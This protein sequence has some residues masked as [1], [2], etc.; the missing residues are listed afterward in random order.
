[1]RKLYLA[2]SAFAALFI[3]QIGHA[4]PTIPGATDVATNDG[5]TYYALIEEGSSWVVRGYTA[6][7]QSNGFSVTLSV[8]QNAIDNANARYT[9]LAFDGTSFYALRDDNISAIN[10]DSYSVLG[11]DATGSKSSVMQLSNAQGATILASAVVYTG[12]SVAEEGFFALRNDLLS[13]KGTD[14]WSL[15]NY[16]LAGVLNRSG[17]IV[18][19]EDGALASATPFDLVSSFNASP[20]QFEVA[21]ATA[22][23]VPEPGTGLLLGSILGLGFLGRKRLKKA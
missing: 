13:P 23:D 9:G 8:N 10:R 19:I 20:A 14:S 4:I 12:L 18:G 1:M 6:N 16:D 7:G 11:F 17:N 21:M 22:A 15:V 5:Q 2:V 3:S